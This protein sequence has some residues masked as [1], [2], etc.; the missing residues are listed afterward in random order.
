MG[1]FT[2]PARRPWFRGEVVAEI[3]DPRARA[4]GVAGRVSVVIL[5]VATVGTSA[6]VAHRQIRESRKSGCAEQL[7]GL[8]RAM[9]AYQE[10]EGHFPAP[11]IRDS[12][13]TPLLSWRVALLPKLGYQKLYEKFRLDEPWDSPHNLALIAEM[14][15]EFACP[16]GPGRRTGRTG[17][18]VIVGPESGPTSVNTVFE[19][20]RGVDLREIT[21][22]TSGTL[23]MIESD[24]SVPWTSPEDQRW[25]PDGPLPMPSSPHRGGAN[26]LF[27][28]GSLHFL[29]ATIGEQ[30]LRALLTINAGDVIGGG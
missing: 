20:T 14:P 23:L 28:D 25:S 2:T 11:S 15:A 16:G 10:A 4:L 19:P 26:A 29:K 13:G 18:F 30:I 1:L 6:L 27:A 3:V 21:D 17:Y 7:R 9:L 24:R 12:G 22:G 8:G 5:T